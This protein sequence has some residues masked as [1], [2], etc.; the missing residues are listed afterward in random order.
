MERKSGKP[1]PEKGGCEEDSVVVQELPKKGEEVLGTM[2]PFLRKGPG[3]PKAGSLFS[4]EFTSTLA[5][6]K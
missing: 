4:E 6:K 1:K 3:R 5:P 2:S